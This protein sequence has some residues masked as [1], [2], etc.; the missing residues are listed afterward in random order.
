MLYVISRY[1]VLMVIV[2][3]FIEF[4]YYILMVFELYTLAFFYLVAN[5]GSSYERSGANVFIIVFGFVLGFGVVMSNNLTTIRLILLVL[6]I[7]KLP[8]YGLHM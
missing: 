6:G 1:T 5:N 3:L 4:D 7:A 8:I 2:I